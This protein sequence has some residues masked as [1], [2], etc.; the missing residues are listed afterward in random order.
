[1]DA[2]GIPVSFSIARFHATTFPLSVDDHGGIGKEIDDI[3]QAPVGIPQFIFNT[4][5]G[6]D[7]PSDNLQSR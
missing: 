3:V 6:G 7:V 2:A 1:M 5:A 4:F